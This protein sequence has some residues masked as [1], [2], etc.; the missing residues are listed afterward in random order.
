MDL[1]TW[2]LFR[3]QVQGYSTTSY[4]TFFVIKKRLHSITFDILS[5]CCVRNCTL[6][7]K[8]STPNR[9]QSK[10][11]SQ[12][13]GAGRECLML[14][15][16]S[17]WWFVMDV[18]A[19][20]VHNGKSIRVRCTCARK[21]PSS[22][23]HY[24]RV[25]MYLRKELGMYVWIYACVSVCRRIMCISVCLL[26][27]FMHVCTLWVFCLSSTYPSS[28]E[29]IALYVG[30]STFLIAVEYQRCGLIVEWH[31]YIEQG[32]TF[33]PVFSLHLRLQLSWRIQLM[34]WLHFGSSFDETS[35]SIRV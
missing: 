30:L 3:E 7:W 31:T 22:S 32:V 9:I 10:F 24:V 11:L 20:E 12:D 33:P 18:S 16:L 17:V 35:K 34:S 5:M 13:D 14:Q 15:E 2:V 1:I 19:V 6:R 4:T 26:Y 8:L 21:D 27:V 28:S 29:P 23:K 25:F